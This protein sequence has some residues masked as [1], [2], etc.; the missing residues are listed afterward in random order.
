M[1]KLILDGVALVE[2]LAVRGVD[3]RVDGLPLRNLVLPLRIHDGIQVARLGIAS[4]IP[5]LLN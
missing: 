4:Q 3:L 5:T 2:P 1:K